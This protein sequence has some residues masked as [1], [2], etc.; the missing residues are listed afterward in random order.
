MAAH[1][2]KLAGVPMAIFALGQKSQLGGAQ[3]LHR[4]VPYLNDEA[5]PTA[6]LTYKLVGTPEGYQQKVYGDED[7]SFVSMQ[8][9]KDGQ[10]VPAWSLLDT[11]DTLWN[12]FERHINQQEVTPQ[13]LITHLEAGNF[14]G[15]VSTVPKTALCL[16]HAGLVSDRPHLFVSQ[17]VRILNES[18]LGPN[19]DNTIV[20]D[21]TPNV[22]WYRTSRIF[23]VGST[24]WGA[25]AAEKRLPY[26]EPLVVVKKPIRTDCTCFMDTVMF[27]GR[28]GAWQKGKLT[29][30][31]FVDTFQ[32][33]TPK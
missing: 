17:R 21:G 23:G 11:Y 5:N 12:E 14:G 27:T 33:V 7:V 19:F 31:A 20:Y 9:L 18:V 28:Y 13:W 10:R 22:S 15:V 24:E 30:H 3:F 1:A 4:A 2:C 16:A 32:M 8:H 25:S 6:E 26:E 29:H